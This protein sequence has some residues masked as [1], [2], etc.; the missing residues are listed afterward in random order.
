MLQNELINYWFEFLPLFPVLS[1]AP[2][3]NSWDTDYLGQI[4]FLCRHFLAWAH[5]KEASNDKEVRK[6]L[7]GL[8]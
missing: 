1:F 7:D 2:A 6:P 8:I 3:V 5:D 4:W